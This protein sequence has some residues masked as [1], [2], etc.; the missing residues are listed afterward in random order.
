MSES[1]TDILTIEEISKHFGGVRAL[2]NISTSVK[3]GTI[4]S[5][6]GP[7]GSGKTT[8]IN[9]ATGFYKPDTGA[10]TYKGRPIQGL[11]P[12]IIARMGIG[13]TFQN[14][15][16]FHSMTV[17]ENVKSALHSELNESLFEA[18]LHL[19]SVKINEKIARER[20]EIIAR[21]LG[22]EEYLK[23]PAASLAYGVRRLVEIARA[24][25]LNPEILILDEPVA[26]MNNTESLKLM[27]AIRRIVDDEG[28]TV[29]LIEHDM[30]VVMSFSDEITVF[31]HGEVIARGAPAE[32]QTNENVI[33]AYLGKA[34]E[35]TAMEDAKHA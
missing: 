19:G 31:D 9:V 8:L 30:S 12:H 29:V 20:T 17:E 10:I 26:G 18:F 35:E 1:A 13:R 27:K 22:I 2:V 14:L 15:R 5:I 3:K 24:L 25:C 33:E 6:I 28:I 32:I 23:S 7:N 16:L 21:K 4:H 11:P 34:R